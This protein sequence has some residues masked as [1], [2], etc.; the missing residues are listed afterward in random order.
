MQ[1]IAQPHSKVHPPGRT[2]FTGE[3]QGALGDL[4]SSIS[5]HLVSILASETKSFTVNE[6]RQVLTRAMPRVLEAEFKRELLTSEPAARKRRVFLT[7]VLTGVDAREMFAEPGVPLVNVKG[8]PIAQGAGDEDAL[9]SEQ[10]SKLLHM[11]RTHVNSLLDSGVLGPV[12]R[13]AG[14]HR[15]I[16]HA[17]VLAYKQQSKQ[18]Q[19]RGLVAMTEASQRLGLY[20][21]ELEGI[22]RH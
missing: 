16:S 7:H 20:K 10:A 6:I 15:R 3:L 18:R 5:T 2:N 14:G 21:G 12:T 1:A 8:A 19:A 17:A 4:A 22:P 11:S 13:T 9:T